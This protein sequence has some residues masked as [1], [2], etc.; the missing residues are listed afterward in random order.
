MHLFL[1]EYIGKF[2][3][4]Y[5]ISFFCYINFWIQPLAIPEMSFQNVT[6]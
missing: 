4:T 6:I 1:L 5:V 2:Q 3:C